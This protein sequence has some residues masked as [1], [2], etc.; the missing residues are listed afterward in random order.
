MTV[1]HKRLKQDLT[2]S[3]ILVFTTI[4]MRQASLGALDYRNYG[5]KGCATN[6][7]FENI[8]LYYCIISTV[9]SKQWI[10]SLSAHRLYGHFHPDPILTECSH[11]SSE[12]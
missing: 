8:K 6:K 9:G 4:Y 7:K 3:E 5:D 12:I 1:Q 2:M 11:F 10:L